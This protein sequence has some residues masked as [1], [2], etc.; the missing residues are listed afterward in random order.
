M[1]RPLVFATWLIILPSNGAAS[2]IAQGVQ[3]GTVRGTI[4]DPQGAPLPG[5]T[6]TI[7]SP[8]LQGQRTA[9]SD[10]AGTYSFTQL[11]PGE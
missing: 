7:T 10:T 2:L 6:V 8:A 3:T 5:V 4:A 1:K 11:P 9:V